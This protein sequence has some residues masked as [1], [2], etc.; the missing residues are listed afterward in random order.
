MRRRTVFSM[1]LAAAVAVVFPSDGQA[2]QI[3]AQRTQ[4][5]ISIDGRLTE[6]TWLRSG[7]SHLTQREPGQGEPGT[8]KTEVWIAYDDDAIYVAAKLSDRSPDSI[9]ARPVRRDLVY[10]DPSDGMVFYLDPFHDHM[11]GYLFYVSAAGSMADGVI[12]ND[13]RY[14]LSW[15]GVWEGKA[16]LCPEGYIVEMRIPFSQLRF[17]DTTSQVWGVNVERYISRRNETDMIAYTPRNES[18]YVS[19]FPHLV[20]L[21]GLQPPSRLE[22]LPYVTAKAEY[23]Q[24]QTNDPFNPGHRYFPGTG[25]DV[26]IGLNTSLTLDGTINPDFG[27][28]EVDP[29]VVNLTDVE[30]SFQE[31][32]P[33]FTEGVSIFRFGQTG[34]TMNPSFGWNSVPLF[35]SRRIGRAPQRPSSDWPSFDFMNAPNG[36]RILGAGK[37]SGR[38]GNDWKIG[39]IHAVTNREFADL[40]SSGLRSS[41]EIEPLTYYGVY[42][43]QRDFNDGRQ[44][45]GIL[46]TY[47]NRNFSDQFLRDYLNSSALTAG[48]DG[49]TYL[50]EEKV[51][52]VNGWAAASRVAGNKNRMIS[53]QRSSAHYFQRP[54]APHVHLDSSA[55]S[56]AGYAGR[57]ML[58]KQRGATILNLAAGVVDPGFETND[59]G[60]LPYS[61]IINLHAMAGY[62]WTEPTAYYQN[63]SLYTGVFHTSDCGGNTTGRGVFLGGDLFA[64]SGY[65]GGFE[66]SYSP[67]TMDVRRTRGGPIMIR[68][69]GVL[70]NAYFYTDNRAWWAANTSYYGEKGDAGV[71][72]NVSVN[73]E[74]KVTPTLTFSVGPSYTTNSSEV[75]YVR[76]AADAAAAGTYGRRYVFAHMDQKEVAANIRVNWFLSPWLSIQMY[77]QPYIA[78]GIYSGFKELMRP[79]SFDFLKYGNSGSTFSTA[80]AA[81]GSVSYTMDADGAGAARSIVIDRPD[82]NY[83]SLRGNAVLRWEYMPGSALFLVWTQNRANIDANGDLELSRSFNQLTDVKPDNIFM[84][85]FSYWWGK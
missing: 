72:N 44:G 14:E 7:F 46:S 68:P 32:R 76:S 22:V 42:R 11:T 48:A 52:V 10:G 21:E 53:L 56:M 66:A 50:D 41:L 63:A 40:E 9:I 65:G 73:L 47:T 1:L 26:K 15:D 37:I 49:W 55:V 31:K 20:G 61:D 12:E 3:V 81:D 35:Y 51:W 77:V 83:Q 43:A 80:V 45:L 78:S 5:V 6:H 34:S 58:N 79:G 57:I 60:Y 59:L 30:T 64:T 38:I 33:F 69:A 27:Q 74:L 29:A 23:L 8:E 25:V 67:A 36:T 62:R 18:G 82:F 54:D 13:G 84:L 24:H 71:V 16:R 2:E 28:V 4:E 19:R 85:K 70:G 75:Q 17:K 39:M